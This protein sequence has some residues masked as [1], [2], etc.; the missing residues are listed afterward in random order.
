MKFQ[1]VEVRE[2]EKE[3]VES[4][5]SEARLT[6]SLEGFD[7]LALKRAKIE[8]QKFDAR[9]A[10]IA[11]REEKER[12]ERLGSFEVQKVCSEALFE[13]CPWGAY[14]LFLLLKVGNYRRRQKRENS[15]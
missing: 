4:K 7:A 8:Q 3:T 6:R 2:L 12:H 11:K 15:P 10:E 1:K 9:E 14:S 13:G 5:E